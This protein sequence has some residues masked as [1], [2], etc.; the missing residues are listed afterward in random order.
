MLFRLRNA[1]A[2]F[3]QLIDRVRMSLGQVNLLAYL[4]DLIILFTT[5]EGHLGD[6]AATLEQLRKYGLRVNREKCHFCCAEV[7]YLGHRLTKAGISTDPDKFMAIQGMA[8]PRNVKQVQTFLQTCSWYR[9]FVPQFAKVSKPLSDL[10]KKTFPRTRE[11][12]QQEAF[13]TLTAR[14]E[15]LYIVIKIK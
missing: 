11:R 3:Q 1:P 14:A 7:K 13:E 6:L 8:E 2:T 9:R 10:T 12:K 4:D 5:F 15:R